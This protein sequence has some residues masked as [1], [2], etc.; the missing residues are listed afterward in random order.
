MPSTYAAQKDTYIQTDLKNIRQ[1]FG[2]FLLSEYYQMTTEIKYCSTSE[3]TAVSLTST[4]MQEE[5]QR[6][7]KKFPL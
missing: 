1:F 3:D 4:V 2:L 6:N 5:I 7:K